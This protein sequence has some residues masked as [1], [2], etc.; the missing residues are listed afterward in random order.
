M[1]DSIFSVFKSKET[2]HL[3]SFFV[4][5][6]VSI[7]SDYYKSANVNPVST[8]IYGWSIKSITG[9]MMTLVLSSGKPGK[10]FIEAKYLQG[11]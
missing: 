4:G 11:S 6:S 3:A 1:F 10:L 2:E 9:S 8:P 5:Q 7:K